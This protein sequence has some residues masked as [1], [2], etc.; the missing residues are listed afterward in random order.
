M[1]AEACRKQAGRFSLQAPHWPTRYDFV[2][3]DE[4]IGQKKGAYI[5]WNPGRILEIQMGCLL[6]ANE[7][8]CGL[9]PSHWYLSATQKVIVRSFEPNLGWTNDRVWCYVW[10]CLAGSKMGQSTTSFEIISFWNRYLIGSYPKV[11]RFLINH[12]LLQETDY[13][14]WL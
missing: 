10:V 8:Q 3:G 5:L 2:V 9:V 14:N 1:S 6:E 4:R 12:E 13:R 11:A 7:L